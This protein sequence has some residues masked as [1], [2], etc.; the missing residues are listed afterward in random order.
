MSEERAWWRN[1]FDGWWASRAPAK[2]KSPRGWSQHAWKA[3]CDDTLRRMTVTTGPDGNAVAVTLTGEDGRVARVLWERGCA[4]S[5]DEL[6]ALD[7]AMPPRRATPNAKLT[8]IAHE[9]THDDR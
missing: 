9:R 6:A 2:I 5:E 4:T 7:A 1:A 8:G 3:A